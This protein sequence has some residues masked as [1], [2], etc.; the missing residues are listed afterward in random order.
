MFRIF[1]EELLFW[2]VEVAVDVG[3]SRRLQTALWHTTDLSGC[4]WPP[5]GKSGLRSG[6]SDLL[7]DL[8]CLADEFQAAEGSMWGLAPTNMSPSTQKDKTNALESRP[9][10]KPPSTFI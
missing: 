4:G 5:L 1:T 2:G 9:L 10:S 8:A 7:Q 3:K 6:A